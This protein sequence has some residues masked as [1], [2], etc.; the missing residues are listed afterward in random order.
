MMQ[1]QYQIL[2]QQ[3]LR[4]TRYLNQLHPLITRILSIQGG[5][6]EDVSGHNLSEGVEE[7]GE[8]D[9]VSKGL[10]DA[11]WSSLYSGDIQNML[12]APDEAAGHYKLQR[13]L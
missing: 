1:V 8:D 3:Q 5:R 11:N 4:V 10:E 6:V 13:H 7:K 12:N 2:S 9:S